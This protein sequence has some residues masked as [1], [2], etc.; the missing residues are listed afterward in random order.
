MSKLWDTRSSNSGSF[1]S[2]DLKFGSFIAK[3]LKFKSVSAF[4]WLL[5][6]Y[7]A[8]SHYVIALM[9]VRNCNSKVRFVFGSSPAILIERNSF[10]LSNQSRRDV[11]FVSCIYGER[12][13]ANLWKRVLPM[14]VFAICRIYSDCKSIGTASFFCDAIYGNKD[15]NTCTTD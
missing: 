4:L 15:L 1:S 13:A 14:C 8:V 9:C 7:Q 11:G 2:T 12:S 5:P 6:G 10:S 3:Q